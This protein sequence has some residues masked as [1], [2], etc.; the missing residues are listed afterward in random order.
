MRA[1]SDLDL[2]RFLTDD[3]S[4]VERA[5]VLAAVEADPELAAFVDARRSDQ[6]RY[7]ARVA[8]R[9]AHA[10]VA[11]ARSSSGNGLVAR[12]VAG[13]RASLVGPMLAAAAC[14]A[15]FF[16]IGGDDVDDGTRT[17]GDALAV[18]AVIRRIDAGTESLFRLQSQPLRA[19]DALRLSVPEG[20]RGQRVV[21]VSV[22]ARGAVVA[23]LDDIVGSDGYVTGSVV[24][25]DS[26][27]KEQ[28]VVL[29]TTAGP[30]RAVADVRHAMEHPAG[31]GSLRGT[32]FGVVA[33]EKE[34][35]P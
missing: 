20:F 9:R 30:A 2:E 29:V 24:L 25:D 1:V 22:D 8:P 17:R 26:T 35:A 3:L 19:G 28:L 34:P 18:S 21:V 14:L 32:P 31:F 11:D 7:A 23:V 15:V 4:D 12:I 33:F 27:G 13:F 16:V 10:A 6:Q 5:R